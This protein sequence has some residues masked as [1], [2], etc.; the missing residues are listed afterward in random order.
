MKS[1]N[2]DTFQTSNTPDTTATVNP[3]SFPGTGLGINPFEQFAQKNEIAH[4]KDIIE[5][6][7]GNLSE[8]VKEIL[9]GQS[10]RENRFWIINGI[11]IAA[12]VSIFL[13]ALPEIY[14]KDNTDKFSAINESIK[15]IDGKMK[16]VNDQINS[17]INNN[18]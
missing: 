18:P 3:Y 11:A 17:I 8:K 2:P 4:L 10:G 1:K 12:L 5:L 7:I 13:F 16:I 14:K 6:K 15:I 9:D